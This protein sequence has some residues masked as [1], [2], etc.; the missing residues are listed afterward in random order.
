MIRIF[1]ILGLI[2]ICNISYGDIASTTYVD[3]VLSTKQNKLT[4]GDG[5]TI[6]PDGTISADVAVAEYETGT[7]DTSGVTKLYDTTG[8]NTDG[9]ITQNAI[10][11]ALGTKQ[12]ALPTGPNDGEKYGLTWDGT[13]GQ[14]VYAKYITYGTGNVDT[15]GITK[16]YNNT[17]TNTDGTITQNAITTALGTKQDALPTGPNDDDQYTLV[18]DG[19]NQQ[20]IFEKRGE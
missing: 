18:W 7:A 5:I 2:T 3:D 11:T 1:I 19:K 20:F 15:S 10:T 6:A 13:S 8:T 9:T 12:D 14:F 16:L 17:G 4:A